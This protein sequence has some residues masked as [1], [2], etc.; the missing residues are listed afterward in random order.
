M[1][2]IIP[3]LIALGVLLGNKTLEKAGEKVVEAAWQ[4]GSKVKSLLVGKSPEK[5]K[6]LEAA[7]E[8]PEDIGVA[9]LEAVA[10]EVESDGELRQELEILGQRVKEAAQENQVFKKQLGVLNKRLQAQAAKENRPKLAES[11]GVYQQKIEGGQYNNSG[12][13]S[14]TVNNN[15]Y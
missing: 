2:P 5:F 8:D 1:E 13:G 15:N 6:A 11:I 9:V 14:F 3:T 12:P 4:Q 10:K 7:V